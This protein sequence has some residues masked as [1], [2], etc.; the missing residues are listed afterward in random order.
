MK[1]SIVYLFMLLAFSS[2]IPESLVD[3]LSPLDMEFPPLP[4]RDDNPLTEEGKQLGRMLFYEK[5]LSRT[6]TISCAS[7]HLQENAFS[8]PNIVSFGVDSLTGNRQAMALFNLAYNENGLFWDGRS[9]TLRHLSLL[10]IQDEKE[11]DETLENVIAK[12]ANEPIYQDQ[13]SLAFGSDEIT[14]EKMGLAFEQFLTSMVSNNSRYDQFKRGEITLTESEIDGQR[15]YLES[16]C[17]NCHKRFNLDDTEHRF[18]NNGLDEDDQM[19]DFGREHITGL[20]SDRAKFKVPSLRNIAVT[21]PY[22]HDGRI[23][24]LAE[25]IQHYATEVKSSTTVENELEDGIGLTDQEITDIVHFLQ[26]FTDEE[27][28]TNP[29]FSDPF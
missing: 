25:V 12:L 15:L 13:F 9:P 4:V 11:M 19:T 28:I 5:K 1:K 23:E 2:C 22:M 20:T 8:D 29:A 18:I 6:N 26:T 24:T 7:C 10:P 27:F 21:A 3:S 14:E 16:A 17:D